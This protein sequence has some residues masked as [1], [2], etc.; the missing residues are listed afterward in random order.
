MSVSFCLPHHVAVSAFMICRGLCVCT[1]M[2]WMCV[3]YVLFG[4]K[5]RP[6]TFGCV[7][8]GCALLFIVRSRLFV[9]FAGS[10][11]NR[12]QVL[13]SGFSKRLFCFVQAKT[14]CRYGCMY[15]LVALV[16]VDVIVMSSA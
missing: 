5:V 12:V 16:C 2:L 3:L 4:S 7:A 8:M 6:R 9:Y 14:L 15:F 11:V 13:L 10:G 1:E